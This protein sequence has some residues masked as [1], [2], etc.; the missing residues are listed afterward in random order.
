MR[1]YT[2]AT[3]AITLNVTRKWLDNTL[4]HHRIDGV[5]QSRQGI[6]RRLSPQAVLT[7]HV[8]LQLVQGLEIPLK[9]AL[10]LAR[11]LSASGRAGGDGLSGGLSISLDIERSGAEVANRLAHAVEMT[12]V[13]RR[14]RPPIK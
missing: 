6:S 2:V 14:G 9:R 7:L 11:E 5:I 8:A 3:A 1:A 13:P 4:S 12:P 10:V